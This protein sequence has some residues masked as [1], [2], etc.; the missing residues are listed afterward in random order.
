M[1]APAACTAG[2]QQQQQPHRQEQY[3]VNTFSACRVAG[4]LYINPWTTCCA[5]NSHLAVACSAN[6]ATASTWLPV[7]RSPK[8]PSCRTHPT[9]WSPPQ[10]GQF[11]AAPNCSAAAPKAWPPDP[12]SW[13]CQ[14]LIPVFHQCYCCQSYFLAGPSGPTTNSPV[15]RC[16]YCRAP[17]ATTTK[18]SHRCTQWGTPLQLAGHQSDSGGGGF[19]W[20][21]TALCLPKEGGAGHRGAVTML[22]LLD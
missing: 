18:C 9:A 17:K 10:H 2:P 6:T 11:C 19:I 7:L 3:H 8:L 22:L 5:D 15:L 14:I 16:C 20:S 13:Q 1:S 12:A 21:N 4:L